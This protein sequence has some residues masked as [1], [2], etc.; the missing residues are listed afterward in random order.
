MWQMTHETWEFA[1]KRTKSYY[2]NKSVY[3]P[4]TFIFGTQ[5]NI[6]WL[7]YLVSYKNVFHWWKLGRKLVSVMES[8]FLRKFFTLTEILVRQKLVSWTWTLFLLQKL[9]YVTES[10]STRVTY[11]CNRSCSVNYT[12]FGAFIHDLMGKVSLRNGSFNYLVY[13]P[14]WDPGFIKFQ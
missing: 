13:V 14:L 1:T 10:L 8:C 6:L 12:F 3:L 2:A 9:I 4:E 5:K 7:I 11:F